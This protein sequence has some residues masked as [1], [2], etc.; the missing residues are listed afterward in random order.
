MILG[1][2]S[3]RSN[4]SQSGFSNP[5]VPPTF[6]YK[7]SAR[8][9]F[10]PQQVSLLLLPQPGRCILLSCKHQHHCS[11]SSWRTLTIY[12]HCRT[13]I[14]SCNSLMPS[15]LVVLLLLRTPLLPHTATF[16]WSPHNASPFHLLL[17]C[18]LINAVIPHADVLLLLITDQT[19]ILVLILPTW[20]TSITD[21]R[22]AS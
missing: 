20:S 22:S 8:R 2:R 11:S 16:F 10:K 15:N 14:L 1:D 21:L 18:L 6:H 13:S 12:C 7:N 17:Y 4:S 19:W 5:T 9:I 3:H